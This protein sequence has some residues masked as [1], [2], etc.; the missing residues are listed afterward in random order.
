MMS[1]LRKAG[2]ERVKPG[3]TWRGLET[4]FT[5]ELV[6]HRQTKET[7]QIG[8]TYGIPRQSSTLHS[9]LGGR[10]LLLISAAGSFGKRQS[11][12]CCGSAVIFSLALNIPREIQ[13]FYHRVG[14]REIGVK[15]LAVESIEPLGD[16]TLELQEF[17]TN[18]ALILR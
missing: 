13:F 15:L 5:V 3:L 4:D 8:F 1:R 10:P 11:T 12:T 17:S 14:H 6:R 2:T 9:V 16:R 18:P 7:E